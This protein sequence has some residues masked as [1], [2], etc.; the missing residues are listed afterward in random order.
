MKKIFIIITLLASCLFS[1]EYLEIQTG[2]QIK[3]SHIWR[4]SKKITIAP[5]G[6]KYEIIGVYGDWYSVRLPAG[7][8]LNLLKGKPQ[9]IQIDK[10][11]QGYV[12]IGRLDTANSIITKVGVHFRSK[13]ESSPDT[14]IGSLYKGTK[15]EII[16]P[17][18][19]WY[20]IKSD[21]AYSKICEGWISARK[22]TV[23]TK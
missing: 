19:T 15:V 13:P 4:T 16:K 14:I 10:P 7:T 18:P 20:N 11:I 5:P 22:S 9:V 2:R 12:W 8:T 6:A 23:V 3:D 21:G 1:T 17:I